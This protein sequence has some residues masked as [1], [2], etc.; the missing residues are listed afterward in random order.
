MLQQ[1][2]PKRTMILV[3]NVSV[4]PGSASDTTV[5]A[6][7]DPTTPAVKKVT[8][9]SKTNGRSGAVAG[10]SSRP[11]PLE[12][13]EIRGDESDE[14]MTEVE[15]VQ[16]RSKSKAGSKRSGSREPHNTAKP[17]PIQRSK[18]KGKARSPSPVEVIVNDEPL[19]MEEEED[20]IQPVQA[21]AFILS[22]NRRLKDEKSASWKKR[23]ERHRKELERLKNQLE[24]VSA[25]VHNSMSWTSFFIPVQSPARQSC[26][27]VGGNLPQAEHRGRRQP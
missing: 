13:Q 18:G 4:L 6:M 21:T 23:E 16:Q 12:L 26:K 22:H 9:P 27:A 17:K 2:H 25:Y 5:T 14:G 15:A 24:A 20:I 8:K 1:W 7:Y 10:P 19:E 11:I 3:G